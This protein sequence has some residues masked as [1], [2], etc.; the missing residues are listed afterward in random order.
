[1]KEGLFRETVLLF[2]FASILTAGFTN[3]FKLDNF[4]GTVCDFP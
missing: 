2:H 3:V 1:M 4:Y